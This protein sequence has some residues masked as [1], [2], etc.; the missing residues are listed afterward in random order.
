MKRSEFVENVLKV[1]LPS[2]YKEFVD[3][4]GLIS[5]ERGEIF[6]YN[7]N[8]KDINKIPCVIGA[9]LLYREDYPNIS[10]KEIV[11]SFDDYENAPIV[12]NTLTGEIYKI[13]HAQKELISRNFREY[14]KFLLSR[15]V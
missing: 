12:L 8:I 15:K 2:D 9:T 3:T 1:K 4:I 7:E 11:I 13:F 5:D 6:G 14:L 10:E